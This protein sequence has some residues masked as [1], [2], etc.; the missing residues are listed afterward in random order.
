MKKIINLNK[1]LASNR[2]ESG[3]SDIKSER[4]F[5]RPHTQYVGGFTALEL[6]VVLAIIGILI[7]V[8]LTGID[9]SRK[10][11]RDNARIADVQNIIL[12]LEQYHD[13]CREY[14]EDIYD[15]NTNNGCPTGSTIT[16]A[17]F[18][19]TTPADVSGVDYLYAGIPVSST[20]NARCAGYHIGAD[21]EQDN[22]KSLQADSDQ[23]T[24]LVPSCDGFSLGFKGDEA[25]LSPGENRY[26]IYKN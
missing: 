24:A 1:G 2:V 5:I 23:D 12:S 18:M 4:G 6:L 26:D 22:N 25:V 8:A 21:L 13:T 16:W 11:A 9:L 7:S 20:P 15:Q 19:P 14:P 17:S 3:D 10:R